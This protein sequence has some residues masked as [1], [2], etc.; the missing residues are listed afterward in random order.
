[1]KIKSIANAIT[2]G[3][4]FS[5]SLFV[6]GFSLIELLVV[7]AIIGILAAIGTVGYNK[8]VNAARDAALLAIA[9]EVSNALKICDMAKNCAQ[10]IKN[11][12]PL[13]VWNVIDG[14]DTGT[15]GLLS[16]SK[17]PWDN[18]SWKSAVVDQNGVW[19][20][21]IFGAFGT[22]VYQ[23]GQTGC[24]GM[25][26][27]VIAGNN[28]FTTSQDLQNGVQIIA[29]TSANPYGDPNSPAPFEIINTPI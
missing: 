6:A 12:E 13:T 1:M 8:Y 4:R 29:C 14:D 25:G 16:T 15:D 22:G 23:N 9:N 2:S 11:G 3:L 24:Y 26:Q 7:V 18:S 20:F 10:Y 27:L 17:N 5:A 21:G 19:G 28:Y